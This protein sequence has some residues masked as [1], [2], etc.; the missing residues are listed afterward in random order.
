MSGKHEYLKTEQLFKTKLLLK[1]ISDIKDE[2]LRASFCQ[3]MKSKSNLSIFMGYDFID[4]RGEYILLNRS[5]M[6]VDENSVKVFREGA[7]KE[8]KE[9]NDEKDF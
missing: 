8:I 7:E 2:K 3:I 1:L 6:L 9:S 5:K 4:E